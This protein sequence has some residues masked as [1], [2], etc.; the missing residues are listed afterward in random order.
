M[1][2][3]STRRLSHVTL[4]VSLLALTAPVAMAQSLPASPLM[5]ELLQ[6]R[7]LQADAERLA[8]MDRVTGIMADSV[9]SGQITVV[10]RE[11]A[12][13]AE[14]ESFGSAVTGTSR[15]LTSLLGR[16]TG[17]MSQVQSYEDGTRAVRTDS[18]D[19]DALMNVPVR[20]VRQDPYGKLIIILNDG[21][22]WRQT[23]SRRVRPPRN[24]EGL[25]VD[26]ERGA[27]GS[28]FMSFGDS[29]VSF[30]ASRD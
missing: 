9:S 8:C 23:D 7:T 16:M 19:I 30:R 17:D 5:D 22:I 21:Q 14:R 3:S 27:V 18:G 15:M 11:R 1:S 29:P 28:F 10:E 2:R 20:E 6:C 4:A 25:T 26:I 13:A 24:T 12:V